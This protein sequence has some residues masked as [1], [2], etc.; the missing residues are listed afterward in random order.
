M[1]H[2]NLTVVD[3][4]VETPIIRSLFLE[5]ASKQALPRFTAGAHLK[6][7]IPGQKVPRCYSLVCLD[8]DNSAFDFPRRY[9]ISVRLEE[10]GTGGSRH[11]HSLKI[12]DTLEVEGPQNDFPLHDLASDE[13]RSV[14]IAGGI[15]ITPIISMTTALKQA[16]HPF[17][18]HY[19]GRSRD[20]MA[21]LEE[22]TVQHGDALRIHAD[23]DETTQL[24]LS[25]LLQQVGPN[26]HLYVCG[27]KGLIDAVIHQSRD[28]QWPQ[29]HVHFELFT[30]AAAL[31]GDKA[32]DLELRQ[33]GRMLH[34]PADK[35]I[36]EVLEEAG[37]DPMYDC[38]RGECGVCQATVLEGTPDHRDYYL[39][40]PERKAGQVMQ[41]CVS[42]SHSDRLVLDL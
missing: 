36:L 16:Q 39:S 35:T 14:L 27:P 10:P 28:R 33:S 25:D 8:T 30:N 12:G 19:Y 5:A 22:L 3:I 18:L 11:M 26:Q 7:S 41:I 32:F 38:R 42:R 40:D 23:D 13:P 31:P 15:G 4:H 17:Q 2:L 29:S 34:I 37:C 9:R 21:F 24:A 1:A 6:V 20:Q